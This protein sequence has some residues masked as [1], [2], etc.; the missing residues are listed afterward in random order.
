MSHQAGDDDLI[1]GILRKSPTL[2]GQL[3]R[4]GEQLEIG[5]GEIRRLILGSII[6]TS[7]ET[8]RA[9]QVSSFTAHAPSG[10]TPPRVTV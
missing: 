8:R 5:L 10:F 2:C 7:Q 1:V 3:C 9:I 4:Q 6:A